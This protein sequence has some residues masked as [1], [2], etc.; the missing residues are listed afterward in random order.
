MTDPKRCLLCKRLLDQ[1]DD[2]LS[3]DCGDDCW[4]CVSEIEADMLSIPVDEYRK[5]WRR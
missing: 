1:D 5:E 4:G 3:D 2:P